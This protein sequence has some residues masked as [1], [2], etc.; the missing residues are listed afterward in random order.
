ML[1]M[2]FLVRYLIYQTITT[3]TTLILTDPRFNVEF[4]KSTSTYTLR[5]EDIQVGSLDWFI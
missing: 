3:G 1:K 5:I 4:E 2:T